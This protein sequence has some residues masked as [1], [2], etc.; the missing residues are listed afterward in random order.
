M[1]SLR[2]RRIRKGV[3][4]LI[5]GG[6]FLVIFGLKILLHDGFKLF[7]PLFLDEELLC[8]SFPDPNGAV[9]GT[10]DQEA[11]VFA[12]GQAPNLSVMAL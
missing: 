9:V 6:S 8:R 4:D 12:D 3:A 5:F 11:S 1:P 7:V 10:G 2:H